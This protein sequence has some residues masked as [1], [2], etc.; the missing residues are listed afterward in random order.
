MN[1][2]IT[3]DEQEDYERQESLKWALEELKDKY[4]F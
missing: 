2:Y 3:D 1:D 4:K